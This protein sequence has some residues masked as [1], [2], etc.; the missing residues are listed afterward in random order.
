[1][2]LTGRQRKFVY[3]YLKDRHATNAAI[4]AGYGKAGADAVGSRLLARPHI[5]AAIETALLRIEER[6]EVSAAKVLEE[7]WKIGNVDIR[8]AFGPDG[9]LLPIKDIPD[10]VAKAIS[11][12]DE[13]ELFEGVGRDREQVGITKKVRFW[14]KH[15]ALVALGKHFKL[16]TEKIEFDASEDTWKLLEAFREKKKKAQA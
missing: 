7:L 12:I 16:F 8:R 6:A 13:D 4:R 2:K 5:K 15:E 11:G 9:R 10:D 1:M 3:E 14:P